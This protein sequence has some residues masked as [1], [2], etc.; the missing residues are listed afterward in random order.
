MFLIKKLKIILFFILKYEKLNKSKAIINFAVCSECKI[1]IKARS[2]IFPPR[3][4]LSDLRFLERRNIS[5]L[6]RVYFIF[7]FF[8]KKI[9][10]L[11]KCKHSILTK[12][13]LTSV[14][15]R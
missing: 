4:T 14:G 9:F 1:R 15:M 3:R 7:F 5:R 6:G 2:R 8:L 10:F 13:R 12:K 11:K